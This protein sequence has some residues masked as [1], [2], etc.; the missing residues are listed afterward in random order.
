MW[1]ISLLGD[2]ELS[3]GLCLP[4]WTKRFPANKLQLLD[5]YVFICDLAQVHNL[6]SVSKIWSEFQ[7][8]LCRLMTMIP[9]P[10]QNV[11]NLKSFKNFAQPT[12]RLQWWKFEEFLENFKSHSGFSS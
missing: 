5:K 11:T 1:C 9:F 4:M 8:Q 12:V 6:T 2:T 7:G 3:V 10:N